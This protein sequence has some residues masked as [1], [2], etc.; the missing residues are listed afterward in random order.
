M[1]VCVCKNLSILEDTISLLFKF[2]V[3]STII[4]HA[5]DKSGQSSIYIV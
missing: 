3:F 1:C 5:C 2:H 4:R